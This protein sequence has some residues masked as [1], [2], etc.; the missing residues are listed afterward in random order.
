MKKKCWKS[1]VREMFYYRPGL[2]RK[3]LCVRSSMLEVS[4]LLNSGF[5]HGGGRDERKGRR[6]CFIH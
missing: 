2:N 1:Y 6:R 4:K 3:L 5:C